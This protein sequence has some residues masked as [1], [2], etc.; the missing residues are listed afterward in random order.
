MGWC[1]AGS[2]AFEIARQLRSGGERISHLFLIDSWLPNYFQ[3]RPALE[4][5]I[6]EYSMRGQLIMADLRR[7]LSSEK[8]IRAFI[9]QRTLYKRLQQLFGTGSK[10]AAAGDDEQATPETY[11]QW[12]LA[13]LQR[14]TNRY[15]PK[16]YDGRVTLI[17]SRLEPTGW[18]FQNDAGWGA[19]ARSGVDVQ[20]VDGNHFTMFQEPGSSQIAA[21]VAAALEKGAAT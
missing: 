14:V 21:A 8:S 7:V 13:Y 9:T 20:F 19:F 2:L 11:D 4:R 1:V 5:I 17:R 10:R 15:T 18:L 12:L 6:G 3:S 16:V